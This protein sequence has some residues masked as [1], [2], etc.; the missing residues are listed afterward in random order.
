MNVKQVSWPLH[1]MSPFEVCDRFYE[2]IETENELGFLAA[3]SIE[4]GLKDVD[5]TEEEDVSFEV[6]LSKANT[7]GKWLK[8]GKV[9]Y[10][11]P[12]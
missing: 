12:K 11:D 5:A 9:I 6:Q 8:D 10:P 1:A 3:L 7:R 2:P 4:K